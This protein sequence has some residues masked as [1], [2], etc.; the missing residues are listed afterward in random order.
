MIQSCR[1]IQVYFA[2]AHLTKHTFIYTYF[3]NVLH[4]EMIQSYCTMI[5]WLWEYRFRLNTLKFIHFLQ[6]RCTLRWFKHTLSISVHFE[7]V[8]L[9]K[10]ALTSWFSNVRC[11]VNIIIYSH[12]WL[13]IPNAWPRNHTLDIQV[14]DIPLFVSILTSRYYFDS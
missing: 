11:H 2:N 6:I 5:T 4:F 3:T 9:T 8:Y 10:Y 13:H 1:M 14:V 7:N 12:R